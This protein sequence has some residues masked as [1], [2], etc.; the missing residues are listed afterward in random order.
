[1]RDLR[2]SQSAAAHAR[3]R[4]RSLSEAATIRRVLLRSLGT[5]W[6]AL[7]PLWVKGLN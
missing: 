4:E 5:L 2:A 1:M 6:E 7:R 3:E